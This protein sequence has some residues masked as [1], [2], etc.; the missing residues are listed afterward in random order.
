MVYDPGYTKANVSHEANELLKE[1]AKAKTRATGKKHYV[2]D[3]IDELLKE[4]YP[5]QF[6]II[7]SNYNSNLLNSVSSYRFCFEKYI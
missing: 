1:I 7:K 3:V 6:A 5:K 4:R 2:Y